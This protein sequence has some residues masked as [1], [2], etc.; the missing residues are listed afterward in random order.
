MRA[1][2]LYMAGGKSAG[3]F[4]CGECRIVHR[5]Q[6]E[7]EACC[8]PQLCKCGAAVE[9]RGWLT[10]RACRDASEAKKEAE[11]YAAAEKIKAAD[12]KGPV[13]CDT[14]TNDGFFPNV[15]D[16][17]EHFDGDE[18]P[19]H[20]FACTSHP[21]CCLDY[22]RIIE[23]ATQEA[24]ED[25]TSE[26]LDGEAELTAALDAFNEKNKDNVFWK[27]DYTRAVVLDPSQPVASSQQAGQEHNDGA[28]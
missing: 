9:S 17:V 24:Y 6:E 7:A 13:W 8:M 21:V 23:D 20:V 1:T 14:N 15:E 28:A 26:S 22:D 19:E 4:F 18:L 5:T 27:V 2:E 16:L 3:I 10:C 25:W 12:W 11:Q